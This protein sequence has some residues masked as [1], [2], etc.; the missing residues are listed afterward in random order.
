[1]IDVKRLIYDVD[2]KGNGGEPIDE[3]SIC[4]LQAVSVLE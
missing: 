2:L 3:L 1:M 4:F